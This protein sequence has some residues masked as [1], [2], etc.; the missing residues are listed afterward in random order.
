MLKK[1]LINLLKSFLLAEYLKYI[2]HFLSILFS[3]AAIV[4]IPDTHDKKN[5]N[6]KLINNSE[7]RK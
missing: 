2:Q 5:I 1:V 4:K 6:I 3:T 7:G